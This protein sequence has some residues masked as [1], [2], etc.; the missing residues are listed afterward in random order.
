MFTAIARLLFGGEEK[1]AD[2]AQPSGEV[3]DEGWLLLNHRDA[4]SEGCSGEEDQIQG[5]V[6]TPAPSEHPDPNP[7][8]GSGPSEPEVLVDRSALIAG[9][10]QNVASRAAALAKVTHA[11]RVQRAQTGEKRRQLTR[12]SLQ[13]QNCARQQ[14]ESHRSHTHSGA[15]LQQPGCRSHAH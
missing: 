10:L 2:D 5:A 14:G 9:V 11:S 1:T 3:V 4:V 13:R 15:Y 6:L 7:G 12:S 8:D